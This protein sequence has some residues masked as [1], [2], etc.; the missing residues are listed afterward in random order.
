MLYFDRFPPAVVK[1]R[2]VMVSERFRRISFI[3][4][5]E[6]KRDSLLKAGGGELSRIEV[7]EMSVVNF[8]HFM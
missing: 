6:G 5:L 4:K 8:M 2:F 7:Y 3:S 1:D